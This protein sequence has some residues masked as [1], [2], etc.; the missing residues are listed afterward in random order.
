MDGRAVAGVSDDLLCMCEGWKRCVS[1]VCKSCAWNVR[2][3]KPMLKGNRLWSEGRLVREEGRLSVQG[4][5]GLLGGAQNVKVALARPVGDEVT[6]GGHGEGGDGLCPR[7]AREE[8]ERHA[9]EMFDRIVRRRGDVAI[10]N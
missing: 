4:G 7:D 9:E 8:H 6:G 5:S 3:D 1:V 10:T 2:R